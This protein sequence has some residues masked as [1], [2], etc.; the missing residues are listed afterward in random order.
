M[1]NTRNRDTCPDPVP[2]ADDARALVGLFVEDAMTGQL[3]YVFADPAGAS[4]MIAFLRGVLPK[5]QFL[6]EPAYH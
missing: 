4:R 5:A 1:A 2:C 3:R 6:I